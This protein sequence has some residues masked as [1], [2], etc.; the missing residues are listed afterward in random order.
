MSQGPWPAWVHD[1][2][3]PTPE[4]IS[5]L[6][7]PAPALAWCAKVTEPLE[8]EVRALRPARMLPARRPWLLPL[9]GTS[10]LALAALAA[11]ALTL[12][13]PTPEPALIQA[14]EGVQ[15]S[16]EAGEA[17][18]LV[19]A[20]RMQGL[21]QVEVIQATADSAEVRVDQGAVRFDSGRAHLALRVGS[22]RITAYD[23]DLQ[24]TVVE[25]SILLQVHRGTARVQS[26][27]YAWAVS[28]PETFT[29]P[30]ALAQLD[31][32]L[33]PQKAE[34][35]LPESEGTPLPAPEAVVASLSRPD[36]RPQHLSDA[37][38][39]VLDASAP[40]PA[41]VQDWMLFLD[42]Q[43][44]GASDA[45]QLE[46]LDAFL[47]DHTAN[48]FTEEVAA[49]RVEILARSAPAWEAYSEGVGWLLFYLQSP[50]RAEILEVTADVARDQMR[51]CERALPLYRELET[52][53]TGA[54][55]ARA[56]AYSGLCAVD[57]GETEEGVAALRDSVD[58]GLTEPDLLATVQRTLEALEVSP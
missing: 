29:W 10:A 27:S 52:L 2:L 50:R 33:A 55:R 31:Q 8:E 42:A 12:A 48:L 19:P 23:A 53:S 1:A 57:V 6:Q 44:A 24:V 26:G 37:S 54:T 46:L 30:A 4:E 7:V 13:R 22:L 36:A 47:R 51:D 56:L 16:L 41:Y 17:R 38:L 34:E 20:I 35:D 14:P 58:A 9:A 18:L 40:P 3:E 28:A 21:G 25:D 45:E 32:G 43:D 5:T 11:L 15:L 39:P 49:Q